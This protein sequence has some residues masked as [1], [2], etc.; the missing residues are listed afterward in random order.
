MP[1]M[2]RLAV[3]MTC[4]FPAMAPAQVLLSSGHV[5]FVDIE[6]LGP[7]FPQLAI[8]IHDHDNG[9]TY[10]TSGAPGQTDWA[11]LVVVPAAIFPRPAST[12]FDPIGVPPSTDFWWLKN[13]QNPAT[14]FGGFS[15][16]EVVPVTQIGSY[17]ESDPRV[18]ATARWI[19]ISLVAKQGPGDFSVWTESGGSPTFWM[20]TSDGIT[21]TDAAFILAGGHIDYNFGFTAAGSYELDFVATAFNA[22]LQPIGSEVTT[23]QFSVV[24]EPALLSISA[25][26]GLWMGRIRRER[27]SVRISS[28]R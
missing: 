22:M 5:D 27:P 20:T 28:G 26:V 2:F 6:I 12:A 24:P 8:N 7:T 23:L 3:L 1:S 4:I 17:F 25:L 15:A 21:S 10:A 16:E 18:N 11:R 13:P 14:L 19:K 9:I